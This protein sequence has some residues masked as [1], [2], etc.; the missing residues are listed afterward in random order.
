MA[1]E[2]SAPRK[3]FP[4]VEE[5]LNANMEGR[6]ELGEDTGGNDVPFVFEEDLSPQEIQDFNDAV[7]SARSRHVMDEDQYRAI[8]DDIGNMKSYLNASAPTQ[9]QTV[10]VVKSMIRV[11]RAMMNDSA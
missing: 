2:L 4:Y 1:T 6:W 10:T 8:K 3:A 11:I 7:G 9:A 5:W